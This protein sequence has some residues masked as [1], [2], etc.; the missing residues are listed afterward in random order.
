MAGVG[1]NRK[2][3]VYHQTA[4]QIGHLMNFLAKLKKMKRFVGTGSPEKDKIDSIDV[5]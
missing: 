3:T 4:L 1:G 2:T 5:S